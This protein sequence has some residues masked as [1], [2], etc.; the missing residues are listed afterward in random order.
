MRSAQELVDGPK[1]LLFSPNGKILACG[2]GQNVKLWD[3]TTGELITTFRGHIGLV[4]YLAFSPDG[5]ILA[6][7]SEDGTVLYWNINTENQLPPNI[8][9]HTDL[10]ET[11]SFMNG[12][13]S[14]LAS[15]DFNGIITLWDLETSQRTTH[16]TKTA[17]ENTRYRL[18]A[19]PLRLSP[20]GTKLVSKGIL[21]TPT[22][23]FGTTPRIRLIDVTTG[24]ELTSLTYDNEDVTP[25]LTFSPDGKTA[26]F[27]RVPTVKF[28]CG[29]QKQIK[30]LIPLS[31]IKRHGSMLLPSLR[32]G[33]NL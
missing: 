31:Q 22:E 20:D 10:V 12:G 19:N 18:E 25:H 4:H 28:A 3:I 29:I 14:T 15:V 21:N 1:V 2:E 17:F 7:A 11:I 27:T 8:T 9:E 30:F 5:S 16:R 33:T 24:R 13:S 23:P 26:V 32:T 6:S